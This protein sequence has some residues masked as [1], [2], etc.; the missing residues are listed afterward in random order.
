[1]G[2]FLLN[3]KQGTNVLQK[4]HYGNLKDGLVIAVAAA[5]FAY[6]VSCAQPGLAN[7]NDKQPLPAS[8]DALKKSAE[9]RPSEQSQ[10]QSVKKVS[11]TTEE[12]SVTETRQGSRT[13]AVGKVLV[14]ARAEQIWKILTDY[15]NAPEVFSNLQKC[16]VVEDKGRNKLVR[17]CVHP[18]GTPLN[19]DYIVE[20]KETAPVLMEWHRKSGALKEVAGSWKLEPIENDGSTKVTYSIY[21]DGGILL[22]AWLLRGQSKSYLPELLKAIKQASE[23]NAKTAAQKNQSPGHSDLGTVALKLH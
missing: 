8:T 11:D 13:F 2:K 3:P 22:P 20:I 5:S 9:S 17:Q 23:K 4:S 19:L 7:P 21:L 1:M 12:P 16:E 18:K 6:A 15:N 10:A 14:N